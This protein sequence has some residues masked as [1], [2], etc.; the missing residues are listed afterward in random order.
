[1]DTAAAILTTPRHSTEHEVHA[2]LPESSPV[3]ASTLWHRSHGRPSKKEAAAQ[4]QYLTPSEEKT[5]A[6][7]ILRWAE[8]G[9][10]VSVKLVRH[11]GWTIARKRSSAFQILLDDVTIRPPGKN[12]PQGFYKRHP[13]LR[14]RKLRPIDWARHD[15]YEKVVDW[16]PMIGRELHDPA[17]LP[18]NVYN[19]DETGN[20]LNSPA[21]RKYV[22]HKDDWKRYRGAAVK[23]TLVTSVECISMSGRCLWPLIIWPASTHRSDWTTHRTPGWHF[24]CS[25]TGYSNTAIVID[26][27]S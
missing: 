7:Y 20:L 6:D 5:L 19:M 25:P 24:A 22:I 9:H 1:M 21:S 12:W 26:H 17:V 8:R 23:R 3:P 14:P 27:E 18:E 4:K 2:A 16:F 15:I 10:P 11:L 13:Q